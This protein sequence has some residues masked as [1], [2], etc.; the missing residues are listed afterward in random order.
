MILQYVGGATAEIVVTK[1]G[2]KYMYF[3]TEERFSKYRLNKETG[4]VQVAP[5]WYTVKKMRVIK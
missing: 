3:T 2:R 1:D 4:E 5:Y